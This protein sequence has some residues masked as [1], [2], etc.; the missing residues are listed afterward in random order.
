[1]LLRFHCDFH[2]NP[3]CLD[4]LRL[5]FEFNALP[6]RSWASFT[7]VS[8]RRDFEFVLTWPRRHFNS[9]SLA[10]LFHFDFTSV[11]PRI[12]I[13]VTLISLRSQLDFTSKLYLT[14]KPSKLVLLAQTF[15]VL[16]HRAGDL[17]WSNRCVGPKPNDLHPIMF[18]FSI[19]SHKQTPKLHSV[20]AK[21]RRTPTTTHT[22][23][24]S[25][26]Q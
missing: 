14:E 19:V 10:L 25:W 1:M 9:K 23:G 12:H 17:R 16:P 3:P 21:R 11:P 5:Q 20:P 18:E 4:S 6:L 26:G 8:L 24:R 22:R 15:F 13:H 2:S 7:T